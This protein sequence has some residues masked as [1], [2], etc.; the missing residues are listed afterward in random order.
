MRILSYC[1][2]IEEYVKMQ[3]EIKLTFGVG[4]YVLNPCILKEK[5]T[6]KTA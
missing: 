2:F 4:F 1:A 6:R 3:V 5:I